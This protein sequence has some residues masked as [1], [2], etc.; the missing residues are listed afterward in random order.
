MPVHHVR[1]PTRLLV[2]LAHSPLKVILCGSA[3]TCDEERAPIR[4]HLSSFSPS[5]P[6]H[7]AQQGHFAVFSVAADLRTRISSQSWCGLS[8]QSIPA[9]FQSS[10]RVKQLQPPL[11]GRILTKKQRARRQEWE[12][13][14]TSAP[15]NMPTAFFAP[16]IVAIT[17]SAVAASTCRRTA[18]TPDQ[19]A[20]APARPRHMH[21]APACDPQTR[22]EPEKGKQSAYKAH[23]S[24]SWCS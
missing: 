19:H 2:P 1:S 21:A 14:F 16:P 18:T 5:L 9:Q 12:L 22:H 20:C 13:P 15:L 4:S 17:T 10:C 23:L 8:E 11:S 7:H 6:S 3:A 24:A